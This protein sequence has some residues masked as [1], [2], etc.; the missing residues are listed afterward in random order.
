MAVSRARW[1]ATA[2]S[3]CCYFLAL[4]LPAYEAF[5]GIEC[6]FAPL[7]IH[8]SIVVLY[9]S[10]WANPLYA[11][12]LVSLWQGRNET[13]AVCAGIAL[14]L[15]LLFLALIPPYHASVGFWFW[16]SS[17]LSVAIGSAFAIG[18]NYGRVSERS[19]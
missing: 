8:P 4:F 2:I 10:W 13:A 18:L 16:L 12:G 14:L 3:A 9:I 11:L 5:T 7:T 1:P 6:L 19:G 17:I 15:V